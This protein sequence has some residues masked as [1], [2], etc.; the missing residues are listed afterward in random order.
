M[1]LVVEVGTNEQ[2]ELIRGELEPLLALIEKGVPELESARVIVPADFD[3][4]VHRLEGRT[5]YRS[6]RPIGEQQVLAL[7]KA[8]YDLDPPTI[9]LSAYLYNEAFDTK[10]RAFVLVHEAIHMVKSKEFRKEP[11]ED[12]AGPI[13]LHSLGVFV[14]EYYA[15]RGA[16]E[17]IESISH[18]ESSYWQQYLANSR[19]SFIDILADSTIKQKLR[20]AIT[21][22]RLFMTDVPKFMDEIKPVADSV[23]ISLA[24]TCALFDQYP[25]ESRWDALRDSP[26]FTEAFRELLEFVRDCYKRRSDDLSGGVELIARYMECFGFRLEDTEESL[27]CHVLDI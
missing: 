13:Y 3:E 10:V 2:K 12:K 19:D 23:F 20:E 5:A 4:A 8:L 15:D 1:E 18:T 9:L 24:H 21:K 14:D 25:P 27:Y 17:V 11:K 7:A 6:A 26:F 22:F 16:Y